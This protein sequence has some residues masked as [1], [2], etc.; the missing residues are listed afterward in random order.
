M[1]IR[2]DRAAFAGAALLVPLAL[3]TAAGTA[4]AVDGGVWDRIAACESGGDW[5]INTGNGYYGGLQFSA[6]TWEAYGG[7]AYAPRA[8][9]ATR[10]QQIAIADKVRNRQGWGAWPTCAA[11]VGVHD[12]PSAAPRTEVRA[13][14]PA[15]P[16]SDGG[17]SRPEAPREQRPQPHT[18]RGQSR[19]EVDGDTGVHVVRPGDNLSAIAAE[20][21]TRW[22]ALWAANR[23][24]V[25]D[26]PDLILPGQR[27]VL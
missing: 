12:R 13:Q 10:E 23:E 2:R 21:G 3:L 8:D 14:V 18:D 25:G 9:K 16:R 22:R 7:T 27:L 17:R 6:A 26:D 5:Q 20:H 1:S 15:R 11:R 19:T 24:V 4:G